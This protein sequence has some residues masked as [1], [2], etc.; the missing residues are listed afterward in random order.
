MTHLQRKT[1]TSLAVA[2]SR[3]Q[4]NYDAEKYP[5]DKTPQHHDVHTK[6][7]KRA[8]QQTISTKDQTP[9]IEG[10]DDA[11][12]EVDSHE[13]AKTLSDHKVEL[14]KRQTYSES[15]DKPGTLSLSGCICTTPYINLI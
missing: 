12:K 15:S 9:S 13:L 1:I 11:P 4:Q 10:V 6:A 7:Q 2:D 8:R 14:K 5:K 3:R